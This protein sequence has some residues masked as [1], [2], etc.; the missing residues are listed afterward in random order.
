MNKINGL[1]VVIPT[2]PRDFSV[3]EANVSSILKYLPIS[4]IVVIGNS[5]VAFLSSRLPQLTFYDE[6]K[7]VN[8]DRVREL[9]RKRQNDSQIVQRTGWYVQQFLKMAYSR[10]CDDEYYLLW[11]SDTIP[12]KPIELFDPDGKPYL[13]YKT[14]YFKEYFV[15]LGRILPGY[16]KTFK[17]SFIAEHMLVNTMHMRELLKIIESNESVEGISFV[18]KIVNSIPIEFLGKS[19]FSEFET[20][21]TFLYRNYFSFYTLR[22]WYS[23]RR[24][25]YFYIASNMSDEQRCNWLSKKIYAISFEKG[26]VINTIISKMVNSN[27]YIRFVSPTSLYI[28]AFII[29]GIRKIKE[30]FK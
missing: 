25:G 3:L 6:S 17:G 30:I 27:L 29:R 5:D 16:S 22:R 2:T 15:T 9:M 23:M 8:I 1:Q 10:V 4:K 19:G 21:G 26:D 12:I 18:E 24:G 28:W 14:E 7:I 11:D 13:D 20:F